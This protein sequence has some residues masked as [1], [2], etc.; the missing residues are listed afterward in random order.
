MQTPSQAEANL[1]C[2]SGSSTLHNVF[3]CVRTLYFDH[4]G[5]SRPEKAFFILDAEGIAKAR[6]VAPRALAVD[7]LST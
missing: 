2:I 5:S 6:M 4:T 7:E 1:F 3:G